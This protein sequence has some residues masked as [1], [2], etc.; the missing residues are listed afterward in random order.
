MKVEAAVK[1]Q[2]EWPPEGDNTLQPPNIEGH[3][4]WRSTALL[5]ASTPPSVSEANTKQATGK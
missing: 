2:L 5:T 4:A 1:P 3:K